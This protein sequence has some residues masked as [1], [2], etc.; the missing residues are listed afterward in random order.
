MNL[1]H[2]RTSEFQPVHLESGN[3]AA[4]VRDITFETLL[5]EPTGDITAQDRAEVE[6]MLEDY[7]GE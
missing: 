6:S 7:G 1:F 4:D 2:C 5:E 3:L